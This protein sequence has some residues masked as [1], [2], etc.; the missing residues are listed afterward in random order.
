M[1][2]IFQKFLAL[3]T[4]ALSRG[5]AKTVKQRLKRSREV[6]IEA[7][8]QAWVNSSANPFS[9]AD[10]HA[11]APGHGHNPRATGTRWSKLHGEDDK[12]LPYKESLKVMALEDDERREA[13]R[14]SEIV[15]EQLQKRG[16]ILR[17][18]QL[19]KLVDDKSVDEPITQ[20]AT[21][22]SPS[23]PLMGEFCSLE[24]LAEIEKTDV[25]NLVVDSL[26]APSP[27]PENV[28]AQNDQDEMSD[29]DLE[30]LAISLLKP[31]EE[32]LTYQTPAQIA[33][34]IAARALARVQAKTHARLQALEA[35]EQNKLS[36]TKAARIP[37][38]PLPSLRPAKLKIRDTEI[39]PAAMREKRITGT[40]MAPVEYKATIQPSEESKAADVKEAARE[41]QI[42]ASDKVKRT[43]SDT[44]EKIEERFAYRTSPEHALKLI[45]QSVDTPTATLA[46]LAG[47]ENPHIRTAVARNQSSN[48]E[49]LWL[50]ARDYEASIRY[51]LAESTHTPL[52]ILRALTKD[53]NQLVAW[54]AQNSLNNLKKKLGENATKLDEK[55]TQSAR[56]RIDALLKRSTKT[57]DGD[58]VAVLEMTARADTTSAARLGELANHESARVRAAVAENSNT[59]LHALWSLVRD[60]D[61]NVKIK[62]TFNCNCPIEILEVIKGDKDSF[63]A[64]KAKDILKGTAGKN[65]K[66]S[67][68]VINAA[69]N[70]IRTY[71]TWP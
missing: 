44:H 70:Q 11:T 9:K 46:R 21:G 71:L 1:F 8:D 25:E 59:P 54:V 48:S 13:M 24:V 64:Q 32:P 37:I 68:G 45:A 15:R 28:H 6:I 67:N 60:V 22:W 66:F 7:S 50:L 16:Q 62:L 56:E 49:T 27:P 43:E 53:R 61:P 31:S 36:E 40:K 34:Q 2:S 69:R 18:L 29:K 10:P 12:Y 19:A 33:A 57:A 41:A 23:E 35:I 65:G 52:D 55:T 26:P 42:S 38:E 3:T 51:S 17:N 58:E 39:I 30:E 20:I 5:V 63:V 14:R 4:A 47:H